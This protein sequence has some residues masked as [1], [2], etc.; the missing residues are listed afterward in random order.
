MIFNDNK[1]MK[2]QR[3]L[4]RKHVGNKY[5]ELVPTKTKSHTTRMVYLFI[6]NRSSIENGGMASPHWWR[7]H[8]LQPIST[9]YWVGQM[10]AGWLC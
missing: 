4:H 9:V 8:K 6:H 10:G 1:P 5:C 7:H 3:E 2:L